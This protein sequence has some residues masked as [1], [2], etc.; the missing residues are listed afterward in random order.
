MSRW[1]LKPEEVRLELDGGDW[2]LV[3]KHLTAGET[4]HLQARAIKAGSMK[5]GTQPEL[6]L[7]NLAT[8][9]AVEYLLDWSIT[10]VNDNPI[11]IRD[12]SDDVIASAL[13]DMAPEGCKV[14]LEA[15]QAHDAAMERERDHQ[16][17]VRDGAT[18]PSP[19]FTSVA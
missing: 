1:Y 13:D 8:A 15:I 14:I 17:K 16:K 5:A 2:L 4:R 19:T 6:D 9:Q 10:D 3:K 7:K 11:R 12:Q 18:E